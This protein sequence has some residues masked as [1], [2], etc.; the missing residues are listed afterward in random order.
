MK[1]YFAFGA[2]ALLLSASWAV[3]EEKPLKEQ[4]VGMWRLVS[5]D[6][7]GPNGEKRQLYGP[8]PKGVLVLSADGQYIQMTVRPDTPKFKINN[9]LEGTS[10]ENKAVLAGTVAYFGTWSVDEAKK[11]MTVRI[12]GSLFPNQAGT[13]STR[14]IE[15][16]GDELKVSNP[17]PGSGW[18]AENVFRRAK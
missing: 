8:N 13:V 12:D 16:A 6:S 7:F 9:R 17:A 15:L 1:R 4:L 5:N 14:N 3:A 11:S 18:R 2:L 10:E